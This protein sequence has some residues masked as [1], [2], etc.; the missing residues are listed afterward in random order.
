V[1]PN[2]LVVL[3]SGIWLAACTHTR[4][5]DSAQVIAPAPEPVV[6]SEPP[7]LDQPEVAAPPQARPRLSRTLTLGQ[8]TEAP[9]MPSAPPGQAAQSQ[10][11]SVV[12]N[13]NVVVHGGVP[14][15]GYGYPAYGGYRAYGRPTTFYSND[16]RGG[17][18]RGTSPWSSTG[19]EGARRTA[20]PGQTPGV[21]GNW[22]PPPSYGPAQM[23]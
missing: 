15:Y 18:Y 14:G 8:G 2:S 12:V 7:A 22:A 19:W 1:R 20:A 4:S 9:Y 10:N 3:G 13:N 11:Q 17:G 21:G 6:M 16:G 5:V 23:K